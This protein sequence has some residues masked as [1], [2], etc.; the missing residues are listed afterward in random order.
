MFD[1]KEAKLQRM[2]ATEGKALTE[3]GYNIAIGLTILWGILINVGMS[4]FL[5]P[6]ITKIDPR[7]AII[8]YLV[9]SIACITVVAK[10]RKPAI[11]FLG[12][13]GLAAAMGFAL[14]IIVSAYSSSTIYSAF[15]AT[16]IIVVAMMIVS[17]IFPSFFLSLGRTLFFALIGAIVIE[18]VGGLI[19][20]LPLGVLDYVMVV[21]FAGYIGFDWAKA[22]AYPRTLG[23]AINSAADIYVDIINIFIRLLSIIGKN[24]K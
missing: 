8:G 5:T 9:V 21:I 18:L 11:S 15:L 22:Q 17:T 16:G 3:N 6:Y 20:H 23:N 7:I 2:G 4:Y 24:D 12:F 1:N 10:S 14:T 13:T 19:F